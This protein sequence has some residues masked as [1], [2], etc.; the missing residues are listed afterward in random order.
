MPQTNTTWPE[1]YSRNVNSSTVLE[2]ERNLPVEPKLEGVR[3]D[4][5]LL[6]KIP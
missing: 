3:A 2:E 6:K 1:I 5:K 4:P